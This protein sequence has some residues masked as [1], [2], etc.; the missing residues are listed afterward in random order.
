MQAVRTA[1][2]GVAVSGAGEAPGKPAIPIAKMML[3]DN[4][5]AFLN[6]FERS[7]Q[8]A[9]WPDDQWVVILIPSLV[10]PGP[11]Q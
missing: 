3:E 1:P 8:A 7:A 9:G 2:V 11:A 6:S 4:P 5:K 10:G